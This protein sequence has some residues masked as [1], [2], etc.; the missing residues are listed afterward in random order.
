[1]K[2][3]KNYKAENMFNVNVIL[4]YSS[5]ARIDSHLKTLSILCKICIERLDPNFSVE[6]KYCNVTFVT[7]VAIQLKNSHLT[8]N[9]NLNSSLGKSFR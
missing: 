6:L 7:V 9:L 2:C 8:V 5:Q 4:F 1:M 3:D